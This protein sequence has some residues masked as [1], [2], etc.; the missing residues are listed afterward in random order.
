MT[1]E[2]AT[3]L[4]V[5]T[6][7]I[8]ALIFLRAAPDLILMGGLTLLLVFGIIDP[9]QA[10]E[11]FANEGLITVA[12]LFVVAEGMRQT[13]GL[14]FLG[15]R[16]LGKP[17]SLPAVQAKIMLPSALM[18]AFMNNTPVVAMTLPVLD[19]WAKKFRVSV[20]HLFLPLS[21][22]AILGGMCT[23][24]GTSTT[25]VVNGLLME[26][27]GGTG[28]QM[29]EIAWIGVPAAI[30]GLI[31][32]LL[33][34]RW[35]LPE[36][37]PAIT[38][39]DDPREYTVEMIVEPNSP[40][41]GKRIEEAGLRH[42][43]GMYLMEIDREGHVLAAVSSRERI[44]ANDRL[45]FVGIV[46][47]VVDLQKIPGLKPATDQ[48][49][50]LD[51]PRAERCLIEAVVSSSCP[52]IRMTIREARFRSH[53]NAAVIAVA[54]NGQ[55]VQSKIGDI[56]LLPGDT[57]LLEAHPGFVELQR[58]SRDFF[59]VSRVEDSTPPRHERAWIARTILVV[60]VFVVA[61]G[62]L[63]ILKAAML[64][65]GLMILT[66]CCSGS[67]AKRSVDWGVLIAIA[68]GLGIGQAMKTSGAAE[69]IAGLL[70]GMAGEN[71][72]AVL[73]VIY[74]VTMVFTNLITA[75]AAAVLFFPIAVATA[76]NLEVD[77]MPFAMAVIVA[78]AA[79][80]ATPI[81]YQTNLMVY[82]PG[83]YRFS[84]YLR[85]G[86]PLSLIIFALT[87]GIVPYIWPF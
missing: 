55:R 20:S 13:G 15:Q 19:D 38:Q 34:A 26:E 79:S 77:L 65:A 24:V 30:V 4:A 22:S 63:S 76:G 66:R 39:L 75:K 71:P 27:T 52:F 9:K 62:V 3:T 74:C 72:L 73:A 1:F 81:G 60:M 58:N 14:S 70:I 67:E 28:L 64:A 36:R 45:V 78:S 56:Q 53:Y 7:V 43:P 17:K 35:L 42:L 31:Y 10:L 37:K 85:I 21:Y 48:L 29:F 12:V 69:Q 59:L 61:L 33:S 18:S 2:I 80:F 16:L 57:L 8:A 51:A 54:R 87:I 82:G 5:L 47:S 41:V 46:E 23:L 32:I 86:S 84:D 25:L 40:L 44:R 50:K 49:F 6:V 11:G 83:G 68:G